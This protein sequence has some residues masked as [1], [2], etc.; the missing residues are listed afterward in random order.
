MVE[1]SFHNQIFV[2]KPGKGIYIFYDRDELNQ[3]YNDIQR[4]IEKNGNFAKDF[5]VISNNTFNELFNICKKIK[6][7]NLNEVTNED[8][9]QL[10][11]EFKE[12]ITVGP[13]ITIQ[14]WGIEA[15]WD[16]N[17][18]L[19]KELRSKASDREFPILK[20]K[21]S[22]ST[23]KSVALSEKESFLTVCVEIQKIPELQNKFKIGTLKEICKSLEDF[24]NIKSSILEHITNFEWVNTEYVSEKWN[25]QKWIQLFQ[26]ELNTDAHFSLSSLHEQHD[27]ALS[28]K[29]KI[30]DQLELSDAS[31]HVL[32]ALNE[33][34]SERDWAKGKFCYALSIYDLLLQE[35]ANRLLVSKEDLLY[36]ESEELVRM[37]KTSVSANV[38]VNNRKD[39][40]ALVSK[41]GR[42]TIIEKEGLEEFLSREGI[43]KHFSPITRVK[44]FGGVIASQGKV[45]GRVRVIEKPEL[46][47]EFKDGEI[48]VTYMTT[49][50]FTPIFGK[51]AGI[52]TDE[53]GLSSHAAII[54]REFGVP[55]IVGT[56]IATRNLKTG[57]IVELNASEGKITILHDEDVSEL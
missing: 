49:M 50:E 48:L 56:T 30:I 6:E 39:G 3:K 22:R 29:Q 12:K 54:S 36:M 23:G 11:V 16:E 19:S 51:A 33:F 38:S 47:S 32:N 14:L 24:P 31:K 52:I 2:G 21:L 44:S 5:K 57:D 53:G 26:S 27:L 18:S 40:F 15:C 13:L 1:F 7:T 42:I 41:Q 37:M 46:M 55:C 8:L 4:S 25:F 43:E 20:G 9:F 45:R 35:I 28:E 17:Y 10:L 34:V